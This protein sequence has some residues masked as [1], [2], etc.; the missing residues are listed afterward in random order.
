MRNKSIELNQLTAYASFGFEM[1]LVYTFQTVGRLYSDL[2]DYIGSDRAGGIIAD[3]DLERIRWA[4]KR[5]LVLYE[6]CKKF[7]SHYSVD[8]IVHLLCY[9][10]D[11]LFT[12]FEFANRLLTLDVATEK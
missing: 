1:Q 7:N 2:N 3:N 4:R 9:Q 11:V 8:L 6:F 12:L 5:N 10:L